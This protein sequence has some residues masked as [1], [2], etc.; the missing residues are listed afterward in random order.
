MAHVKREMNYL[1]VF[2]QAL[3]VA[4]MAES[5][6]FIIAEAYPVIEVAEPDDRIMV[7][8]RSVPLEAQAMADG[9]IVS[10]TFFVI[11]KASS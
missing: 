6:H 8:N 1:V 11:G 10:I 5:L 7:L 4:D 3:E 2:V 9:F